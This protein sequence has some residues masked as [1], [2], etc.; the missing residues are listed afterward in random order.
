MR[1]VVTGAYTLDALQDRV[2]ECFSDIPSVPRF[3]ASSPQSQQ[4]PVS[5]TFSW[6]DVYTPP[7]SKLVMPLDNSSE[8]SNPSIL[9]MMKEEHW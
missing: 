9:S 4:P 6:D 5:P 7:M 2:V 3:P 1:L 8:V